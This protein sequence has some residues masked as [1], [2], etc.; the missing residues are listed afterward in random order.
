MKTVK[1]LAIAMIALFSY[2]AVSASGLNHH[3]HRRHWHHRR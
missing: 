1:V 2:Q 3:H